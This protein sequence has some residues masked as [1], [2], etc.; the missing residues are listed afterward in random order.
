VLSITNYRPLQG[1]GLNSAGTYI[2]TPKLI[3][4]KKCAINVQKS[5]DR[6]FVLSVLAALYP[7]KNNPNN[8]CSYSKYIDLLNLHGLQFPFKLKDISKFERQNLNISVNVLY[9]DEESRSFTVQYL[10][11]RKESIATRT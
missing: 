3:Q 5:D 4:N 1:S 10:A 2:P 7:S 9:C 6:C 8:A 11:F